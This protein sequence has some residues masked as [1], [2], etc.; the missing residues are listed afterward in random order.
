M[1]QKIVAGNWKMNKTFSEGI[2]LA[3]G[4]Q[5]ALEAQPPHCRVI[6]AP[7][8]IH[9]SALAGFLREDIIGLAAQNAADHPQ[10]AYT[11]EVSAKMLASVGCRYVIIGHSERR[12]YY[13][14]TGSILLEKVRL[15]LDEGLTPIFCVGESLQEREEGHHESVI[16]NQLQEGLFALDAED[17]SKVIL[18]YEPVWAIGT[19]KTATPEEANAMHR[20]IRSE[21]CRQYGE[22][23]AQGSSIL[24]GGSCNAGNA[25]A[26]FAMS[27][28]DGGLIGG[29]SLEVDKFLPIIRAFDE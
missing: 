15:A 16:G 5:H 18:A 23:V 21:I 26:L 13:H 10:G 19:G 2:E 7:P 4:I 11:G 1:R 20:H 8:Y 22:Y 9:L 25:S 28:I 3:K 6:L 14:E 27:D 12:A 24:Y 17:F 29:A